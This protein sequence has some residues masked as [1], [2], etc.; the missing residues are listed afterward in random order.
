M[1]LAIA[2]ISNTTY[3]F[4]TEVHIGRSLEQLGH[5]VVFLQE[6]RHTP[7]SIETAAKQTEANLVLYT[8]TWGQPA[9][10]TDVWRRLEAQG[11][12]TASYH[13]DLYLGLEREATLEGDPFWSTEFVFTPDGDPASQAEFERRGINHHFLPP[14][15]VADECVPGIYRER[16]AHDV[17]F[18]GSEAYHHEWSHRPQLIGWLG[19][20]Y[21]DR[22][23]RYGAGLEIVRG[24]HLNDLRASAKVEVGDSLCPGFTHYGYFS[25]RVTECLG[26]GG[27]LL[28]PD[29]PGL[30]EIL[31]LVEDEHCLF[32]QYGDFD[33]VGRK[34]EWCLTHQ[35]E[36]RAM[37]L[38]GQAHIRANHTYVHRLTS[39]LEVMRL[40][41]DVSPDE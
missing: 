26:R 6:D 15:V 3:S 31:G 10:L 33:G 16:F 39:A 11:I 13:L 18:V 30:R 1:S 28:H 14:A 21:G 25:D 17:I 22:F 12:R 9:R 8:R 2:Y 5:K 40:S 7:E 34:V 41:K 4:C 27:V 23:Q 37:A 20:T 35:D 36:A 24:Q 19:A 29:V 38:R 32:Y